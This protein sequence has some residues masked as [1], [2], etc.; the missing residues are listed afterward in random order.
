MMLEG[1]GGVKVAFHYL[2]TAHQGWL[3]VRR[4]DHGICHV[5]SDEMTRRDEDGEPLYVPLLAMTLSDQPDYVF[6]VMGP[7]GGE[8]P[9]LWIRHFSYRGAVLPFRRV[10]I[11][12]HEGRIGLRN[13]LRS[14]LCCTAQ[15]WNSQGGV[16]EFLGDCSHLMG[17]EQF[18]LH[19]VAAT[20]ELQ[21]LGEDMAAHFRV[22]PSADDLEQL[23][24]TYEGSH[25]VWLLDAMMPVAAWSAVREVGHRLLERS[26]LRE[27]LL[28]QAGSSPWRD[29]WQCLARW[30]EDR[31]SYPA[32]ERGC[33]LGDDVLTWGQA[34]APAGFIHATLHAARA[35]VK[36]RKRV[37]MMSTI[38]NEGIY[39]LEWIAYHRSIGVEHFF[40]Y[41]NDNNDRS[42]LLLKALHDEGVITFIENPVQPGMSAQTKAYG[43]GLN[44]LPNIL[45]YEWCFILDGDEFITLAPSYR[46][47]GEYLQGFSRWESDAIALNWKFVASEVNRDGLADLVRP[48]TQRNRDIVSRGGIGEG[49]RLVKSAVRPGRAIQSRPHHPVWLQADRFTYRLSDGSIHSYRNPPPG[50]GADPAF[51]DGG[52][53]EDIYISHYYY[54]SIIEWVWKYARNSGLDGAMSFGVERYADY[55]ANA[56]IC[57]MNDPHEG[58]NENVLNRADGLLEEMVKLRSITAIAQAENIV[59]ETWQERLLALLDMVE[60]ADVASRLKEEWRYVLDPL[61]E[62]RLG[63]IPLHQV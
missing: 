29:G 40:I 7:E 10:D 4:K 51:A 15:P 38:R 11:V 43:H 61:A 59:R 20:E 19:E 24:D 2:E 22:F 57:Q 39:V 44:V 6:L 31:E 33:P 62:E 45:D 55:W 27:A 53:Y 47:V 42:D 58:Q 50:I 60:E 37:C 32:A 14:S 48:L 1:H 56:F 41:S 5:R 54:K 49:W 23:I 17:W 25:L 36:P 26:S 63:S 12:G 30:L 3:A 8:P 18:Q 46:T 35:S 13:L 34:D 21:R 28:R 52:H 9:L 16:N